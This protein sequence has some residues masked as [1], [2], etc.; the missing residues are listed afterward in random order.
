MLLPFHGLTS[1][2]EIDKLL[3]DKTES[4]QIKVFKASH[5]SPVVLRSWC[6][7]GSSVQFTLYESHHNHIKHVQHTHTHTHVRSPRFTRSHSTKPRREA[8]TPLPPSYGLSSSV[9]ESPGLPQD[10]HVFHTCFLVTACP[11]GS[12]GTC[13]ACD[14]FP[15][16][17]GGG[18]SLQSFAVSSVT[19]SIAN[20]SQSVIKCLSVH[21]FCTRCD[22]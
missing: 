9:L 22:S 12:R 1:L 8:L 10:L 13:F 20:V 19:G 11:P 16:S 15:D 2:V 5:V 4:D 18:R 21:G 7:F 6:T 17:P 14:L 3:G